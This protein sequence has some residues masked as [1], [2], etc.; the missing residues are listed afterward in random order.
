MTISRAPAQDDRQRHPRGG[1][2]APFS[3]PMIFS[4][5]IYPFFDAKKAGGAEVMERSYYVYLLAKAN[6]GA[7]TGSRTTRS[8]GF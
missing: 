1:I 5:A 8:G 4:S 7:Y 2:L 3:P 6:N